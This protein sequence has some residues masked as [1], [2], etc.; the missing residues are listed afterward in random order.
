MAMTTVLRRILAADHVVAKGVKPKLVEGLDDKLKRRSVAVLQDTR[1]G[2][3]EADGA[4]INAD[5][6]EAQQNTTCSLLLL[7]IRRQEEVSN[8]ILTASYSAEGAHSKVGIIGEIGQKSAVDTLKDD[9]WKV[10]QGCNCK[11]GSSAQN[12]D[13][14]VAMLCNSVRLV[15]QEAPTKKRAKFSDVLVQEGELC[16]QVVWMIKAAIMPFRLVLP[17]KDHVSHSTF[18]SSIKKS[19]RVTALSLS[20]FLMPGLRQIVS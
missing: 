9:H 5:V 8:L 20:A 7:H 1:D 18:T 3:L 17:N 16:Q 12:Q 15:S 6:G 19:Q 11:M 13:Q 14:V 10:Q 2:H 4:L